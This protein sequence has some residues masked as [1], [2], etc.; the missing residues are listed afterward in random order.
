M[1][2]KN[3]FD[4]K[5]HGRIF[6]MREGDESKVRDI[7]KE[8]DDGEACYMPSNFITVW[9]GNP[10]DIVYAHKFEADIDNLVTECWN[11]GVPI[12]CVTGKRDPLSTF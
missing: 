8:I 12:L 4:Y 9:N 5:T 11:R 10:N 2:N 7:I 3:T 6:V 1:R